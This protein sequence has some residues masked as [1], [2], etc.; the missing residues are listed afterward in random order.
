MSLILTS[1]YFLSLILTASQF[2]FPNYDGKPFF[3]L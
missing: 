3:A 2:F 1:S